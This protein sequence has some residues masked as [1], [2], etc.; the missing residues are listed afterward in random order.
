M[1]PKRKQL[2]QEALTWAS[3]YYK[4]NPYKELALHQAPRLLMTIPACMISIL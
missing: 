1:P 3:M 4:L 2:C